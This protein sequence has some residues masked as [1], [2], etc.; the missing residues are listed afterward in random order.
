ML[1]LIRISDEVRDRLCL[2]AAKDNQAAQSL[3]E[4]DQWRNADNAEGIVEIYKTVNGEMVILNEA[5][6]EIE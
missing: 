2:V 1:Q 6:E 5:G 3:V 4:I